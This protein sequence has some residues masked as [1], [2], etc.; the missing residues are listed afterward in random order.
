M[1]SPLGR[2]RFV[3]WNRI[4]P[5]AILRDL[6]PRAAQREGSISMEADMTR[7]LIVAGFALAAMGTQ[8]RA[9]SLPIQNLIGVQLD[10][11]EMCQGMRA[12][13][14]HSDDACNA[15]QKVTDLLSKLGYCADKPYHWE[16]CGRRKVGASL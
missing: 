6:R 10:L 12:D 15:S 14:P 8:A 2:C 16:R 4:G 1:I 11:L 13:D 3:R 9:Q 7:L 5:L